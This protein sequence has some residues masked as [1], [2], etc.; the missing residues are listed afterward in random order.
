MEIWEWW[1][2]QRGSVFLVEC[3]IK[4]WFSNEIK[5][6]VGALLCEVFLGVGVGLFVKE[7]DIICIFN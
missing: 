4:T 7:N 5:Q 2:G 6:L 3:I 1:Q